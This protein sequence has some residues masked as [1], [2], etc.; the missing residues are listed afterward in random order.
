[1][2]TVSVISSY[3][4]AFS[5]HVMALFRFLK[6]FSSPHTNVYPVLAFLTNPNKCMPGSSI[7]LFSHHLPPPTAVS[8]PAAL[9]L[10]HSAVF[11][12]PEHVSHYICTIDCKSLSSFKIYVCA[13]IFTKLSTHHSK[14]KGFFSRQIT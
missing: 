12:V 9:I 3:S 2:I 6:P 13:I 1:M 4:F 14:E 10:P 8:L 7:L 11:L 5:L